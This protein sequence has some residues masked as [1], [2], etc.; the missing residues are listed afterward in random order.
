MLYRHS[1]LF[2]V[3]RALLARYFTVVALDLLV[4]FCYYRLIVWCYP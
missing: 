1:L 4:V 3:I 2:Y